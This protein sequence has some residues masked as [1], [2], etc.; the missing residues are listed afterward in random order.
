MKCSL[1]YLVL[2][3][4]LV[5]AASAVSAQPNGKN[6][7]NKVQA[8]AANSVTEDAEGT[9]ADINN[10]PLP[11]ASDITDKAADAASASATDIAPVD[12]NISVFPNPTNGI[13]SIKTECAGRVYFYSA[14]GK[15]KGE[16]LVNEGTT[17]IFLPAGLTT[18]QYVCK[19]EGVNGSK[20]ETKVMFQ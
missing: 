9:P 11:N 16:C 3:L 7:K 20:A 15:A 6:N 2:P 14:K 8:I 1:K 10:M 5:F 4:F 18:G 17:Q 12:A 19:F 13:L